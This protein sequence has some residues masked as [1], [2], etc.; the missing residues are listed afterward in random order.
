MTASKQFILLIVS[1]V[2]ALTASMAFFVNFALSTLSDS[3]AIS[4]I[5]SLEFW[6]FS[7]AEVIILLKLR[8]EVIANPNPGKE[9][10]SRLW[11]AALIAFIILFILFILITIISKGMESTF[12][13]LVLSLG[14]FAFQMIFIT[15]SKVFNI[16]VG[17]RKDC[18]Q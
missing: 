4:V 16:I 12:G 6:V 17:K 1:C 13:M 10:N 9:K 18:E 7:A 5:S 15:K 2:C 11:F 8:K 14:I 3:V